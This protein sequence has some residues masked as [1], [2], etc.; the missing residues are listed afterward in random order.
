MSTILEQ[1]EKEIAALTP[2]VTQTNTGV[3]SSVAD[4]VAKVE[5]LSKVMYNEMVEFPGGITGIALNLEEDE[6][7]VVCLGDATHLKE[8]DEAK[9]TGRLLSVPVGKQL[10]G[11]VVDAIGQP[12]DGKGPIESGERYPIEK[13]APGII[14][15][16][17]V[18][19][20]LQT[21]IMAIDSMIPIGRGQ[22]ELIIGDRQTGKTTIAVDTI[23][24]QGKINRQGLASGDESFRP[25]YSDLCRGGSEELHHCPHDQS[26]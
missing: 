13:I 16:K 2:E 26:L 17:S 3:I 10:L 19:Q 1:I 9:T 18:D 23:I 14:P 15:R 22:R 25:V 11:R 12:V 21:G 8:G 5:G 20:P 7:G 4:G 24:N 6:V